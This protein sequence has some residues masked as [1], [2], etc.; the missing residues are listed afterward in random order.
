MRT[1]PMFR[2]L[3]TALPHEGERRYH[4]DDGISMQ[5]TRH[6]SPFTLISV[7]VKDNGHNAWVTVESDGGEITMHHPRNVD[8]IDKALDKF[9]V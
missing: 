8:L 9:I 7:M 6:D 2:R 5:I 3:L 1:K 4:S